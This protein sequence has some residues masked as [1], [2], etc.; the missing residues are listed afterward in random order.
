MKRTQLSSLFPVSFQHVHSNTRHRFGQEP[1]CLDL[2]L[3]DK[4]EIIEN[5]KI[6]G[7][8]TITVFYLILHVNLKKKR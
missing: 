6:G 3:S 2:V 8:L 7:N 4:E 5:L 1:S